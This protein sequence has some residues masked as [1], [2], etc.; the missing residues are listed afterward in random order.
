MTE[1]LADGWGPMDSENDTLT[2]AGVSSLADRVVH[3]AAALGR[4]VIDDGRWVAAALADGGFFS[5]AGVVVRPPDD[6]SWLAS[7][8][9]QL[10]PAGI[11]KLVISPFV[12]PDLRND[13][14]QLLG[15][16]PFMVRPAGG[17]PPPA[18]TDLE[19][20]E[21]TDAHDLREFER[22]LIEGYPVHGMEVEKIP[23]LF[24]PSFLGESSHVFLGLIDGKPVAT[25]AA[26]V[27]AGVNHVEFVATRSE[28][29]G[30]GFGAAMTWAATIADPTLPAVLVASDPGRA[31]Y[32]ALGYLA[33]TRWTI[34]LSM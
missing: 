29:R 9:A 11:P 7:A 28:Y 16:P 31:I 15:H 14:L 5:N 4:P 17:V 1:H 19:I 8:L 22:T 32:E 12:T 24:P 25:A 21:I 6:W 20:R 34:W 27:S 2:R 3:H 23:I 30:R 10:A 13:G 18:V 33:V 26:H